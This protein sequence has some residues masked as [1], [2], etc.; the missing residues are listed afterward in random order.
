MQRERRNYS[1]RDVGHEMLVEGGWRFFVQVASSDE[2]TRWH[3]VPMQCN[4]IIRGRASSTFHN[5]GTSDTKVRVD[6]QDSQGMEQAVAVDFQPLNVPSSSP[7]WCIQANKFN[8]FKITR[9]STT[10][11]LQTQ[12]SYSVLASPYQCPLQISIRN[13]NL[14]LFEARMTV[15]NITKPLFLRMK[16]SK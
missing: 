14:I 4:R 2:N 1:A 15:V 8:M 7:K 11:N 12:V 3:S 6:R 9:Q 10:Y 13:Y 5:F 16:S